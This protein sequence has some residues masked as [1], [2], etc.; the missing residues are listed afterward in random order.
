STTISYRLGSRQTVHL[1][2]CDILGRELAVLVRGEQ[3]AGLQTARWNAG[4]LAA[5][6]YFF[7]L[8]SGTTVTAVKA[9]LAR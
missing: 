4:T 9:V 2:V 7:R 5:G 1:S 3:E 8:R 6:V